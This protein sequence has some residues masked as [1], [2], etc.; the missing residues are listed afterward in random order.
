MLFRTNAHLIIDT[1]DIALEGR[2]LGS[3]Y[4]GVFLSQP[5]PW[6]R[7]RLATVCCCPHMHRQVTSEQSSE[8]ELPR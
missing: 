1:L 5:H 7:E 6:F 8:L 2:G 4:S 3:V